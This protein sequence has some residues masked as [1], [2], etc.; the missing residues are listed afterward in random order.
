MEYRGKRPIRTPG[1]SAGHW[2]RNRPEPN[3]EMPPVRRPGG[4]RMA[5]LLL[6]GESGLSP[7]VASYQ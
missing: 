3:R 5:P 2:G 7:D 4:G 6:R 1:G